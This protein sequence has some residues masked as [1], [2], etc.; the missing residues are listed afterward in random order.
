MSRFPEG[1]HAYFHALLD[2]VLPARNGVLFVLKAYFDAS[3]RNS[4]LF[5]VAGYAFEKD[6]VK[7][8]DR[9][10]WK[11][12]GAYGGC[13]MKELAHSQG[14]FS[15]ITNIQAGELQKQAVK[16]IKA[17]VSFGVVISCNLNEI[18]EILPTWIDGFQHAYPV[19]CN[20]A[21][22]GLG[23]KLDESGR[24]DEVAYFFESGDDFSAAAHRFMSRTDD[25]PVLKKSYHHSSHTFISKEK[26]LALQ[27]ADMLA[28]EWAKYMDETRETRVRPMRK[29][30]AALMGTNGEFDQRYKGTHLTGE[31]LRN[32]WK[33]AKRAHAAHEILYALSVIDRKRKIREASK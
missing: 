26:A 33:M 12:F 16:V 32:A 10:W 3:T 27:A 17:R 29:S 11:I 28:W 8:F 5:C 30:L 7:K 21:M 2:S 14:R 22:T 31:P 15:G 25:T 19:C 9:E 20:V 18:H 23:M 13:H 24:N 4:G 6:Q 1:R